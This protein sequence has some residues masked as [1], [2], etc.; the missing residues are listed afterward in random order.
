MDYNKVSSHIN[1][2]MIKQTMDC[3]VQAVN[4]LWQGVVAQ[5]MKLVED[6][7]RDYITDT[8]GPGLYPLLLGCV[9]NEIQ[10][11]LDVYY[12]NKIS[13]TKN[14]QLTNEKIPLVSF[15]QKTL[16]PETEFNGMSMK[17]ESTYEILYK[18]GC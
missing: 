18:K 3:T 5:R 17:I 4:K 9:R 12:F 14:G 16:L 8:F 15:R 1:D 7:C 11:L 13:Y 10:G 2:E 6:V